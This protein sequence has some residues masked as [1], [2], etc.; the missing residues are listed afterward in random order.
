VLLSPCSVNSVSETELECSGNRIR[1]L[2]M[3]FFLQIT[4]FPLTLMLSLEVSTANV[5][6]EIVE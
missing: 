5:S 4:H 1:W 2:D 3:L 6:V